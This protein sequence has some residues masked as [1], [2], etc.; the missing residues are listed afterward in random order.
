MTQDRHIVAPARAARKRMPGAPPPAAA[1]ADTQAALRAAEAEAARLRTLMAEMDHRM[2]NLLARVQAIVSHSA[3][4][5]H[6]A[7]ELASSVTA[8]LAALARAQNA[9]LD[10][11]TH[12]V[13]IPALAAGEAAPF[14][15]RV[16]LAG[17]AVSV[18]GR[19]GQAVALLLHELM[20]N[21]AKYG[22]LSVPGG[23]VEVAWTLDGGRLVLDWR[24]TG[25]PKVT[26][27]MRTGFGSDLIGRV[28]PS[29]TG[30]HVSLDYRPEG[31]TA[32]LDIPD[33]GAVADAGE[34]WQAP[35]A[36]LRPAERQGT[37][38]LRVLLLEDEVL[39]AMDLQAMLEDGGHTVI[40]PVETVA[41]ALARLDADR[42]DAAVL[43]LHLGDTSSVE[44]A[45]ALAARRI[46]FLFA[47]GAA[48]SAILPEGFADR[49]VL[50]KPFD[51]PA[52]RDALAEVSAAP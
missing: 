26:P 7:G 52:L 36:A 8:R 19:S 20:T 12:G 31:V 17:P 2:K 35:A 32:R 22:A 49:P 47:T 42:P 24:E 33:S 46:P 6:D 29:E 45:Q 37:R 21:A 40:G 50:V 18:P 4:N 44:V 13:S 34:N 27:P 14:G 28:V 10:E 39:I 23:E 16:K 1:D 15:E 48:G 11:G 9:L 25:G 30:G 38:P 43:D 5:A 3:R 51:G 41:D